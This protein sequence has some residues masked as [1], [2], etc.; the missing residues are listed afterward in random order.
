MSAAVLA[1]LVRLLDDV[2]GDEYS[3]NPDC[4]IDGVDLVEAVVRRVEALR[5][6]PKSKR[7]TVTITLT[8]TEAAA[9]EYAVGQMEHDYVGRLAKYR[10]LL[11]ALEKCNKAMDDGE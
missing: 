8:P 4:S 9:L 5:G 11:R 10:T 1:E 6:S 2:T 3:I 7:R